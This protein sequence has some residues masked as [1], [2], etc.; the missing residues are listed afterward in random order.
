MGTVRLHR[1]GIDEVLARLTP[2]DAV[3]DVGGLNT[4][5]AGVPPTLI[6]PSETPLMTPVAASIVI[7]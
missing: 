7:P 1:I 2:F 6:P 4:V 5:P 3:I